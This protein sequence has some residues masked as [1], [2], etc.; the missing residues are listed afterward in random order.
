MA[1][2]EEEAFMSSG[3]LARMRKIVEEETA[4]EASFAR[5]LEGA[6]GVDPPEDVAGGM[7]RALHAIG[8]GN[9][10]NC[11]GYCDRVVKIVIQRQ[12]EQ[13][14]A[15]KGLLG[16][17]L[18]RPVKDFEYNIGMS[19]DDN[20]KVPATLAGVIDIVRGIGEA[21][22][23][24][25]QDAKASAKIQ[26]SR[27]NGTPE[28]KAA[29][30]NWDRF[31]AAYKGVQALTVSSGAIVFMVKLLRDI[32]VAN[33][34]CQ[35]APRGGDNVRLVCTS[36][37]LGK[38]QDECSCTTSQGH[39][40]PCSSSGGPEKCVALKTCGGYKSTQ[41]CQEGWTYNYQPCGVICAMSQATQAVTDAVSAADSFFDRVVAFLST[42]LTWL[43]WG[44]VAVAV[45]VFVL[46]W[47]KWLTPP[48]K[49]E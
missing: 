14:S 7:S 47:L 21:N 29:I 38:M 24:F 9:R 48:K 13:L 19:V 36:T 18:G 27:E 8:S 30:S 42:H 31:S 22:D 17:L 20:L 33:S 15:L 41:K 3:R 25:M 40:G 16:E 12:R 5:S 11:K 34:F 1:A 32:E 43:V 6:K 39:D 37:D 49:N 2:V 44:S 35:Q 28:V 23:K 26:R 45:L 4:N 46:P 10:S